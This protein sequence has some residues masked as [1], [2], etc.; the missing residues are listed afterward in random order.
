M[1][2]GIGMG[3]KPIKFQVCQQIFSR[4]VTRQRREAGFSRGRPRLLAPCRLNTNQ[5]EQDRAQKD[6]SLSPSLPPIANIG[7]NLQAL[8]HA[9]R[10]FEYVR[11][12]ARNAYVLKILG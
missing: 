5:Q 4:Q 6:S 2:A 8:I 3:V 7:A 10:A 12:R 11:C 9:S 1:R